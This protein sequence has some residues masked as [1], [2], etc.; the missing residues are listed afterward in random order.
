MKTNFPEVCFLLVLQATREFSLNYSGML[1]GPAKRECP[2]N[3]FSN[4]QHI[5]QGD[6]GNYCKWR[7][8]VPGSLS[9]V[10]LMQIKQIFV[11]FSCCGCQSAAKLHTHTDFAGLPVDAGTQIEFHAKCIYMETVM[12]FYFIRGR[13]NERMN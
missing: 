6:C 9:A 13:K 5:R 3:G 10:N 2:R 4:V 7:N 11:C 1:L 8:T 12:G